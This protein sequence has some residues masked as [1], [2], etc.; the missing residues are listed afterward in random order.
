MALEAEVE[1]VSLGAAVGVANWDLI[2]EETKVHKS[3]LSFCCP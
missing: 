2:E 1:V 3:V